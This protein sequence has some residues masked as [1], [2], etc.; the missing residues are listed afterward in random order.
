MND[1]IVAPSYQGPKFETTDDINLEWVMNLIEVFRDQKT[2][3]RK[4]VVQVLLKALEIFS[5][6][7]SLIRTDVPT[8]EDGTGHVNVCGDTHGQFYDVMHL[9]KI[10]GYPSD[11]NPYIFNGDY[12]DRGSFSFEVIFTFLCFKILYPNS[13]HMIR[14]NHETKN[15]NMMYGF[16]GEV[17][18]KYDDSVMKLFQVI[19]PRLSF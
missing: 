7:K 6:L 19:S 12:V 13:M 4:Y 16:H 18:K 8:F 10:N 5:G 14:G 9:F 2:V 15:M 3:H 1:F 11:T 17:N